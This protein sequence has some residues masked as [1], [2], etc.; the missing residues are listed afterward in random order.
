MLSSVKE[1]TVTWPELKNP[2]PSSSLPAKVINVTGAK[3]V[4]MFTRTKNKSESESDQDGYM[5]VPTFNQS[6]G[7][8][9]AAALEKAAK[10]TDDK[11][12]GTYNRFFCRV[13]LK[14]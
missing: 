14:S 9:V 1:R 6:F 2:S 3:P 4:K 10:A 7:D 5:P 13:F 12:R 8:A 11:E